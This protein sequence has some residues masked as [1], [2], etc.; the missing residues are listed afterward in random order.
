MIVRL[1]LADAPSCS[2]CCYYC[3]CRCCFQGLLTYTLTP[4]FFSWAY[5][6]CLEP[7][8]G[9]LPHLLPLPPLYSPTPPG[10]HS[11]VHSIQTE[12]LQ[13]QGRYQAAD[14]CYL[15]YKVVFEI[16][17]ILKGLNLMMAFIPSDDG[18]SVGVER[19]KIF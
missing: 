17:S 16:I 13:L 6:V 11:P 2:W 9:L 14:L 19:M 1:S 12:Q 10:T 15:Y 7:L 3:F 18:D 4:A 8:L 5:E